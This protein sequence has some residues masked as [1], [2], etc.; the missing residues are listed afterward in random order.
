M[1]QLEK[2]IKDKKGSLSSLEERVTIF[3]LKVRYCYCLHLKVWFKR[4]NEEVRE[5]KE[6]EEEERQ[7]IPHQS[8][9]GG[10]GLICNVSIV[11]R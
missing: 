10:W 11:L 1:T 2:S 7:E 5:R 3:S 4:K 6:K 9:R 8:I